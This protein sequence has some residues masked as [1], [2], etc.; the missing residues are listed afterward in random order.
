MEGINRVEVKIREDVTLVK[1]GSIAQG[2]V[3]VSDEALS[4]TVRL[5]VVHAD[6][7]ILRNNMNIFFILT[8]SLFLFT[9]ACYS[10]LP[11]E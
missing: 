2:S 8:F 3:L 5:I 6:V 4:A 7:C 10:K 1:F 11:Q 9:S